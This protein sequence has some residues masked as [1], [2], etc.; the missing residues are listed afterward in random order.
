[1][2]KEEVTSSAEIPEKMRPLLEEF[3]GVVHDK[4]SKELPPMRDIQHHIHLISEASLPN[5]S[6]YQMNPKESEVLKE[7]VEELICKRHIRES[8]SQ[9]VIP[10]LLTPN[11]D[12]SWHMCV[13]S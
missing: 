7:K 11:K 1:M 3:K 2:I 13:D 10:V 6:H 12:E 8:M 4:F 9:C 5:L